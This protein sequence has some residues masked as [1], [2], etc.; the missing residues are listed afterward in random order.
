[1]PE[2]KKMPRG[3]RR[4]RSL[5]RIFVRTP[6]H[7]KLVYAK[8]KHSKAHCA[9]CGAVLHGVATGPK[10]KMAKL[11]KTEKR[12]E[13]PYAGMLCSRCQRLKIKESIL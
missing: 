11:S 8:R 6:K 2:V 9:N 1:M 4:S 3:S 13:R 12:P 7:T 10:Y 5:R